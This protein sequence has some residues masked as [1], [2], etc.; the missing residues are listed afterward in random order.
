MKIMGEIKLVQPSQP[1]YIRNIIALENRHLG[2]SGEDD[3][4]KG[5]TVKIFSEVAGLNYGN[6]RFHEGSPG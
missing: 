4:E 5:G 1:R 2:K 3:E 6:I